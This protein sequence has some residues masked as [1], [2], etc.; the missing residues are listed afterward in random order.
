[1]SK[2]QATIVP[3]TAGFDWRAYVTIAGP[4]HWFKN[5]FML[6]GVLLAV[7]CHVEYLSVSSIATLLIGI[8]ATCIVASSNYVINEILDALPDRHHPVKRNR[9]IPSGR[10]WL[11]LAY[12]EWIALAV[13]GLA[14]R[15]DH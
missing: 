10:V 2:S 7:F 3:K 4:D 8:V 1:M 6:V 12:F 9:P 14:P 5:V 15:G 11:P 13:V